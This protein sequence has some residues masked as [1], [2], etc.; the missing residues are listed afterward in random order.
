M[1]L[2]L[3]VKYEQRRERPVNRRRCP[4][5]TNKQNNIEKRVE[6]K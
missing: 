6:S 1:L 4:A 2:P 5:D 3:L